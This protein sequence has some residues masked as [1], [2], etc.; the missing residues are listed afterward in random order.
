MAAGDNELV[1]LIEQLRGEQTHV[2]FEGLQ[3]VDV[4]VKGAM[5]EHGTQG[6]VLVDEFEQVV[7]IA[8]EV[9]AHNTAD[10]DAPQ[11]HARA[12]IVFV[13][14]GLDVFFQQSK[15]ALAQRLMDVEVL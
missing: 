4:L 7:V 9:Q 13:D 8:V 1:D 14:V 2:V 3:A 12:A 10:Q 15:D 5:A 11:S 6:V